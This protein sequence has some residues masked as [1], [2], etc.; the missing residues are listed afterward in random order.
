[1]G[2]LIELLEGAYTGKKKIIFLVIGITL[3]ILGII[4]IMIR[5]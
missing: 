1:M 5:L 3:I 2:K 4:I